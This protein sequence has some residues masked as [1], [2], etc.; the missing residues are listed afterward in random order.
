MCGNPRA[1]NDRERGFSLLELIIVVTIILII[2]AI[3]IPR[4]MRSQQSAQEAAA[5]ALLRTVI[6]SEASHLTAGDIFSGSFDELGLSAF[7]QTGVGACKDPVGMTPGG[8]SDSCSLMIKGG[9]IFTLNAR[10]EEWECSAEPIRD[11]GLARY[12]FVDEDGIIRGVRGNYAD[13]TSAPIG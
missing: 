11:R 6:S 12:L 7:G 4:W 2:A 13:K 1:I 3:A 9:Y 8:S 5:V 10:N